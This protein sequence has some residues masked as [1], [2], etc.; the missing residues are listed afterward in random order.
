MPGE[1]T[2]DRSTSR[3]TPS[4]W[5]SRRVVVHDQ[6]MLPTLRPGDRLLVD[7]RA[8]R[9]RPPAAGDIVVLIDPEKST[10]WLI[11][12]VAGVGPG[13]FRRTASG[14]TAAP[15]ERPG[16]EAVPGDGANELVRLPGS[17]LWVTGDGPLARDSRQFGPVRLDSIVGRVYRCYA[18][19]D[20]R[21]EL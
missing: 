5:W 4:R 15:L 11:K 8:Y 17:M 3:S 6:S 12:R 1:A 2:E 13:R 20:R 21:R 7:R 16:P 9:N 18:P 19:A 10:R 14:L